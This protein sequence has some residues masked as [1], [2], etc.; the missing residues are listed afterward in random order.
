M[1]FDLNNVDGD[2]V[3]AALTED[4]S[5]VTREKAFA[6]AQAN[7]L[8]EELNKANER[9][10]ELQRKLEEIAGEVEAIKAAQKSSPS[11][12]TAP[13]SEV[14]DGEVLDK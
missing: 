1:A 10:A 6:I 13:K 9:N 4:V 14:I 5:R 3:I 7:M 8:I 2:K 12:K 11:S